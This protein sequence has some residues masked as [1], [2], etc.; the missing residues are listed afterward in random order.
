[1]FQ[2]RRIGA[3]LLMGG[4][5]QRFGSALPKQFH[6][7]AG[8]PI[9][10]HTLETFLQ[11]GSFDEIILSCEVNQIKRVCSSLPFS[12]CPIRVIPGGATRQESSYKGLCAFLCSP[13]FVVIHDAVRPFVSQEIL[14]KNL[15]L[16]L[17]V[18]AVDTCIPSTDTLVY[19]PYRDR[20]ES[21]PR[22]EEYLRG[23]TPQSFSYPLVLQAHQTTQ[24]VNCSDDCQLVRDLGHPIAIAPGDEYNLKIT[25][26]LDLFMA[27]QLLRLRTKKLALQKNSSLAGK[28][29]CVIGGLGGI[30]TAIMKAIK[31]AKGE[32]FALSRQTE[33]SLDLRDPES[34]QK[35]LH[36]LPS[37]DGLINCAGVLHARAT[38]ELSINQI[39]E[40]IDVN[41]KG[42]II[43]CKMAPLK[44]NAHVINI[45]S[46]SFSRG[47]KNL[48]VYSSAKAGVVNFTQ[49]FAEERPDLHV[50]ALVPK[51]V[52]TPLRRMNF[53]HD[54]DEEWLL[55]PETVADT[56]VDLLQQEGSGF[57]VEVRK[58]EPQ[59]HLA[60][61]PSLGEYQ[62]ASEAPSHS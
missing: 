44:R 31:E 9:Y 46:S 24:R 16:A 32:G 10:L 59:N 20:I 12:S 6:H 56:V 54:Q 18:G 61:L 19:A 1:M 39:E 7:L 13:Q 52:D 4:K 28:T 57:I 3:L 15:S 26:E 29:F 30:G 42:L 49:G 5:G 14:K 11:N 2:K 27:E 55:D 34:I 45:A 51:R 53:P 8:K 47:R 41:L 22:R 21:I 17:E 37:L 23:Q 36:M 62:P 33:P 58:R 38:G 25:S 50:H 40:L 48:S 43:C 35:T 60:R